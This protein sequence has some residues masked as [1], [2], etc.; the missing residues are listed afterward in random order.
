MPDVWKALPLN[1]QP[2]DFWGKLEKK[3]DCIVAWHPLVDHCA[4][5]AACTAALLYRTLLRR[6]LA[7]LAGLSD[8]SSG[9][10]SR[11]CV[12]AALHD[13]GKFNLGFQKKGNPRI[14]LEPKG[15]V[16]EILALLDATDAK[17]YRQLCNAL[18]VDHI[19]GWA[20]DTEAGILPLLLASICHHGRPIPPD[21]AGTLQTALW[22]PAMGLDPF[23]GVENLLRSALIW[24]PEARDAE[25]LPANP[26]FQHAF[27]G[28][29][30][31]A[32]WLGS[33]T[34]MFPY[35]QSGE[36]DRFK[37]SFKAACKALR[38]M[39]LDAEDA[40]EEVGPP[41]TAFLRVLGGNEMRP[42]QREA[43]TLPCDAAGSLSILEAETGS[44][45]TEAAFVRYLSLLKQ[46]L[47]D[48]M[49]FAL[50]TRTA[51]TQI[52]TRI[53]DAVN[54]AFPDPL[55][56]PPVILAVPGYLGAD[57]K[58]GIRLPH[59]E[60]LWNDDPDRRFRYRGWAAEHSKRYLAG[61]VSIGTIDQVL[62][63]A[64]CVEHAHLRST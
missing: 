63:S 32:D 64:L 15:H 23:Q 20:A 56:R 2:Q 61:A 58:T 9:Q 19:N 24:F 60:V 27:S 14:A 36:L 11:L 59:F 26:A 25:P 1:G 51:A 12:L 52:Y 13:I 41:A 16:C 5:V 30:M 46:G 18:D 17:A 4:D 50:P 43:L 10:I 3:D 7:R 22:C 55:H 28:L 34:K 6:R 38:Q 53:G 21:Q 35:T 47:V 33:D 40:R 29:V 31:L 57:G 62:L 44:G 42:L 54:C 39:G 37:G 48:G 8:L 45:K 49:Y